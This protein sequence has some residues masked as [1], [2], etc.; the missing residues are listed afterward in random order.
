MIKIIY[1]LIF[2][3]PLTLPAQEY[4]NHGRHGGHRHGHHDSADVSNI[5]ISQEYNVKIAEQEYKFIF[6]NDSTVKVNGDKEYA[7]KRIRPGI[8]LVNWPD[9]N[10]VMLSNVI[11]RRAMKMFTTR[12]SDTKAVIITSGIGYKKTI[13]VPPPADRQGTEVKPAKKN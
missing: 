5:K 13:E 9:K 3:I 10:G 1:T 7:I 2:F 6:S 4:R 12:L 11:D 8:A